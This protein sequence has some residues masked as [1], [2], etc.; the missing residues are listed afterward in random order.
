MKMPTSRIDRKIGMIVGACLL[1]SLA[2]CISVPG[3]KVLVTPI[4]VAGVHSF[5]PQPT[6]DNI[7]AQARTMDR[8]TAQAASENKAAPDTTQQ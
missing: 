2:G 5:K 7:Y 6:P 8:V 1:A 3:T 4:G